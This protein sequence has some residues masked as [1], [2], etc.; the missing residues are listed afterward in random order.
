M[1]GAQRTAVRR[2]DIRA[3]RQPQSGAAAGAVTRTFGAV[4]SFKQ[5]RELQIRHP[6][7]GVGKGKGK[8]VIFLFTGNAQGAALPSSLKNL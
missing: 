1:R 2:H 3:D 8:A 7:C 6:W 5:A 4:E